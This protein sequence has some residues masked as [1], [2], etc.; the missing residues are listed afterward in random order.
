MFKCSEEGDAG[1]DRGMN[2]RELLVLA[3]VA[4]LSGE[5][6]VWTVRGAIKPNEL[7]RR[8]NRRGGEESDRGQSGAGLRRETPSGLNR[9]Q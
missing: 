1:H 5:G 3:V 2:R 7:G 6:V 4:A 9:P 8:L